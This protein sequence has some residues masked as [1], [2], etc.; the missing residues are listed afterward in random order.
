MRYVLPLFL[1]SNQAP[2]SK[3]TGRSILIHVLVTKAVAIVGF[4]VLLFARFPLEGSVPID[5]LEVD[6]DDD[7]EDEDENDD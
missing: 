7:E 2:L 6:D 4:V 3:M 1:T 5:S